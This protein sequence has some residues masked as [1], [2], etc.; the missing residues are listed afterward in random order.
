MRIVDPGAGVE[1]D[2]SPFVLEGVALRPYMP[3]LQHAWLRLRNG[4]WRAV[5]TVRVSSS[6]GTSHADVTLWVPP[7]ALTLSGSPDTAASYDL[8]SGPELYRRN[9]E[10]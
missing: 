1:H 9:A 6:S 7:A 5:V 2:D 3:G 10:P 8:C 4:L